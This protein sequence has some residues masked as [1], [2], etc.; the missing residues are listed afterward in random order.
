[1][2]YCG[3]IFRPKGIF[4]DLKTGVFGGV[5]CVGVPGSLESRLVQSLLKF[6]ILLFDYAKAQLDLRHSCIE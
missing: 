1:M 6:D 4:L 3:N 2:A 5:S